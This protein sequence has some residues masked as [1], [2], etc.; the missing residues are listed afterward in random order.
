MSFRLVPKSLT[1]NDFERLWPLFCVI[2]ANWVDFRAHCVKWLEI[3]VN[4]LHQK[5]IP[6]LLVFTARA[7]L[8]VQALY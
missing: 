4:Y 8:A 1:L 2:S 5:C 3:Y 6:K 7:M